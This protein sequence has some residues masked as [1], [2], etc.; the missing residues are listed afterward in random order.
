MHS[1]SSHHP[2][3]AQIGD[4]SSPSP[5][6]S[7]AAVRIS[8]S[9]RDITPRSLRA[10]PSAILGPP[11]CSDTFH[12][13]PDTGAHE[14]EADGAV[15]CEEPRSGL[16]SVNVTSVIRNKPRPELYAADEPPPPEEP[17]DSKT[18]C[19]DDAVPADDGGAA[20]AGRSPQSEHGDGTSAPVEAVALAA[21][22]V[23]P[24]PPVN[25]GILTDRVIGAG[26]SPYGRVTAVVSAD[27]AL[28]PGSAC[29]SVCMAGF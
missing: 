15:Y 13:A 8:S 6:S 19:S 10:S 24:L 25:D 17:A 23:K 18:D 26:R 16:S 2:P 14:V 22:V 27:G 9:S 4:S 28:C 20:L 3:A 12:S 7:S 5:P 21:V 29:E 11:P 1:S